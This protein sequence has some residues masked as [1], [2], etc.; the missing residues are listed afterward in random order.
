MQVTNTLAYWT[1]SKVM[2]KIKV[3]NSTARLETLARD[4][5]SSLL[6]KFVNHGQQSFITLGQ[7]GFYYKNI[8]DVLIP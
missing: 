5:Q 6:P 4:K 7:G 8:T 1:H 2:K 3:V